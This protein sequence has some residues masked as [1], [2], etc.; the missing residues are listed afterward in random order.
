MFQQTVPR[1]QAL[2]VPG[3][4]YDATTQRVTAWQIHDMTEGT[5]AIG[6]V[7]TFDVGVPVLG[8]TGRFAGILVHSRA[9]PRLGGLDA[10]LSVRSESHIELADQGRVIVQTAQAA[11]VGAGVLYDT[12]TGAIIGPVPDAGAGSGQAVLPGAHFAILPAEAGGL[13][14]IQLDPVAPP[15]PFEETP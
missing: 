6:R 11:P 12:A 8:G 1:T 3:D 9:L 7:F 13:G 4:F 14:V 5:Q 15:T 2:G 10:N